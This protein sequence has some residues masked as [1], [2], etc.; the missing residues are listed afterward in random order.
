MS[1]K[2]KPD[3]DTA[4]TQCPNC[5]SMLKIKEL[6]DIKCHFCGWPDNMDDFES[7]LEDL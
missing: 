7:E 3:P 4:E 5:G 6:E 2:T 1:K